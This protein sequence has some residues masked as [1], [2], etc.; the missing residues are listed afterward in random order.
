MDGERAMRKGR[1]E[2][3]EIG[4]KKVGA[5]ADR[6]WVEYAKTYDAGVTLPCAGWTCELTSINYMGRLEPVGVVLPEHGMHSMVLWF[7]MA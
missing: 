3:W 2:R 7:R 6:G 4:V 1:V 5:V